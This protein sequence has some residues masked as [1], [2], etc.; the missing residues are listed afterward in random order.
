MHTALVGGR[1]EAPR[2]VWRGMKKD[3]NPAREIYGRGASPDAGTRPTGPFEGVMTFC[4]D[5]KSAAASTHTTGYR[6]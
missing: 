2:V 5:N 3:L 4:L 1:H 6:I